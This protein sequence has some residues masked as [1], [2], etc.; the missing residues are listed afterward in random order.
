[1]DSE[2]L[3]KVAATLNENPGATN[4]F[5]ICVRFA[6][7]S[8]HAYGSA[9]DKFFAYA[10]HELVAFELLGLT[11]CLVDSEG[12]AAV[13]T[14]GWADK[15]RQLP[16]DPAHLFQMGS[17]SKSFAALCVYRL[18]DEGEIDLDAPLS[19][20]LPDA[21]LPDEPICLQQVLSH[22]SG[23]PI[24]APATFPRVPDERLW[25]GFAAGSRYSYSNTGYDL[26]GM[27]VEKITGKPYPVARRE[28]VT[29]PL[30]I[31]AAGLG[32]AIQA[33]DRAHY[34]IGYSSLDFFLGPAL[35]RM[36]TEHVPWVSWTNPS[37]CI[38]ATV[39]AMTR[40]VQYLLAVGL[41][42]GA[43]LLSD[44]AAR[45]FATPVVTDPR[46]EGY[47]Y[48]SGLQ[49][50]NLDGHAV[51]HHAGSMLGF[52]SHLM[53]DPVSG[54]GC[55]ANVNLT[56]YDPSDLVKYACRLLRHAREGGTTPIPSHAAASNHVEAAEIY[57]GTYFGPEGDRFQLLARAGRLSILADDRE[58]WLQPTRKGGFQS[59]HPRFGHHLLDF[60]RGASDVTGAWF[61]TTLDGRGAQVPQPIV[62]PK[63][64]D[65]Q[66]LYVS[67]HPRVWSAS[68][69]VQKGWL[70]LERFGFQPGKTVLEREDDYWQSTDAPCERIR[71][72]GLQDG[73]PRCLNI[74]GHPDLWRFD[75]I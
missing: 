71:F 65:L 22:T 64:S 32:E 38:A 21:P 26:L 16:V 74:S 13:G 60:E 59:D 66:G 29:G 4:N 68:I 55:F 25:T 23:L 24:D 27:L 19:Y 41:G 1:M 12:F 56:D 75:R 63:L 40:Y 53:V 69:V 58:G 2:A 49:A 33:G 46:S 62:P 72:L 39:D 48:A 5:K 52:S 54:V 61:G 18:A 14:F 7:T 47:G 31:S 34:V 10:K 28:L 37:S 50:S 15:N 3:Q 9:I 67:E 8:W 43:P 70:V 30:G 6:G 73:V 57:A 20:Y 42:R 45:R 51:L 36:P 17:I 35:A 11:F 44:A